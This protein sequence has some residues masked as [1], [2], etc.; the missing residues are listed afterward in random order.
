MKSCWQ[1]QVGY[2]YREHT[3][4]GSFLNPSASPVPQ[5]TLDWTVE[6]PEHCAVSLPKGCHAIW[7]LWPGKMPVP[8]VI[9][10]SGLGKGLCAPS[11]SHRAVL[12]ASWRQGWGKSCLLPPTA[13]ACDPQGSILPSCD[14]HTGACLC[15]EGISGLKCQACAC[16]SRGG[17]PHCMSCPTCFTS[18]DLRLALLQLQ[19]EIVAQK[20]TSLY[21]GMPDWGARGQGGHLQALEGILQQAPILLESSSPLLRGLWSNLRSR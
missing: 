19:L 1:G 11:H 21:Q 9:L 7:P 2:S 12:Q 16:G 14:P 5:L 17:F 8:M 13:C 18:W 20:V 10:S 15:R 4:G 3:S 6:L